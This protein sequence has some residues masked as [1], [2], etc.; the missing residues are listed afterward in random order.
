MSLVLQ[1]VTGDYDVLCQFTITFV[2]KQA[3]NDFNMARTL[4]FIWNI[5]TIQSILNNLS[6]NQ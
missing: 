1:S 4:L 2:L 5:S 3:F 6:Q